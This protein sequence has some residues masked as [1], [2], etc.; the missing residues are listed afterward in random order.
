M[1]GSLSPFSLA[2]LDIPRLRGAGRLALGL[3]VLPLGTAAAQGLS[4]RLELHGALNAAYG[5]AREVPIYGI[6]TAGTSD[7][8]V[9]TVQARYE[10][11]P[12]D[13]IV[14][15]VFNRRL[16]TS[17][18]ASAIS[19]VTMQWAFW[20]HR[21]GDL[22]VKAGRNPLPR[23]LVNEV[24]YI[25]TVLPFFRP[26]QEISGEAF[27]AIDGAV[28]SYRHA[29]PFGIELEQH[30]FVG[31][32]EN[33]AIANTTTGQE[34]RVARTEN[35][36]GTQTYFDL[37]V[38]NIRLGAYGARY[39][40]NQPTQRGYRT[41]VVFSGEASVNRLKVRTEQGRYTG[42]GPMN[43]NRNGYVEATV[44]LHERLSV[45][46]QRAYLT[47][48]LY[49]KDPALNRLY[50]ESRSNGASM[51]VGLTHNTVLK[52]ENHWRRGWAFDTPYSVIQSQTATSVTLSPP[53]H[54]GYSLVSIAATF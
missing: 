34:V 19:D 27:D 52:V 9:F 48:M 32:S 3:A 40:F 50:P 44:K 49:F 1:A 26:A 7:Y 22:T 15:Q 37:P 36:F 12:N 39:N 6:P 47:R 24:R 8:R 53:K 14:A 43:D 31:G 46:G 35:M 38:L 18:M 42:V 29:L 25:G 28:V 10:M 23:G 17:P 2:R 30:G 20:Q 45:A 21:M 5:R 4:D 13:Q 54:Y 33:R 51:I 41:N 16:G 11:S